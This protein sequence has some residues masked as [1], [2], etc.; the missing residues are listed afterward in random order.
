MPQDVTDVIKTRSGLRVSVGTGHIHLDFRY[1]FF[2][3]SV[4]MF[5]QLGK[6]KLLRIFLSSIK[7]KVTI[8]FL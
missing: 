2:H 8:K 1:F 7:T 5:N 3:S 4:K 6:K